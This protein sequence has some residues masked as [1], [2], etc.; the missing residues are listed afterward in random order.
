[1]AGFVVKTAAAS[2]TGMK[3][4]NIVPSSH[5]SHIDW[6]D[7]NF[8][9]CIKLV[10]FRLSDFHDNEKKVITKMY[11]SW[12]LLTVVLSINILTTII[13]SATVLPGIDV[14][15]TFLNFIL[16]MA[17]ATYVFYC[18]YFGIA[19]SESSNLF[20][21]KIGAVV[22]IL[23]YILFSIFPFGA[24]NGWARIP[25]LSD[26]NN[27]AGKFG[28]AACVIESTIYTVNYI[29]SAFTLYQVYNDVVINI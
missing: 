29:L 13:L 11:V 16:G 5:N 27:S 19:R 10:H 12:I 25:I 21:Y 15:Y 23:M 20:R 8:P 26:K 4:T 22:L 3:N 7:Y 1:M 28:V 6:N 9:P 17:L 14:L 2:L 18:G 24:I